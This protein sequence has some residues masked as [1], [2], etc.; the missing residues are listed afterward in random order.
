MMHGGPSGFHNAPVTRALVISSAI[1]TVTYGLRGRSRS[2]GLSYQDI[3][4]NHGLW[5]TV[6]S[7]FAFSSSPELII[8]LYLIYYFRV[9]ERQ[10]GSN[11]YSVFVLFS[12][13]AS[14]FF[15]IA[16]LGL[17]KDSQVLAS[18]PYGLI[19]AA[20]VPFYFDIPVT[21]RFR[22]LGLNF[23]NKSAIYFAGFQLVLSAWR[24]SFIPAICGLLTGFLFR[25]NIFC[26]RKL[27][28]PKKLTS[29]F[30]WLFLSSPSSSPS[31]AN[32]RRNAYISS[33]D[34]R[35]QRNYRSVG[36]FM[37]EP[38]ESSITT[39]VS[40]GF[41]TNAARQALIQ[42]RN[43]INVATNILLEAQSR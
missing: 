26:I 33:M 43:D 32:I 25:A 21:S 24:R 8:G 28:F 13:V 30:S 7:I 27:K 35:V 36:N 17:L 6:P 5:K 38:P 3:T 29:L 23:S 40:M 42:A 1:I 14:T 10:I 12:L 11:K 19:F 37:P 39:L 22:M 9:F 4:Q 18:G 2:I 31:S 20:F 41:E 34:H 16:G 15:Q